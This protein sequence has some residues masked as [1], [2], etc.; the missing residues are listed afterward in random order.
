MKS[1]R[2]DQLLINSRLSKWHIYSAD[3]SFEASVHYALEELM[4]PAIGE[5]GSITDAP[6]STWFL[7]AP[8]LKGQ[9]MQK[10][11]SKLCNSGKLCVMHFP[12]FQRI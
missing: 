3:I 2:T 6:G 4:P 10:Q 9:I 12:P 5:V 7:K 8:S 11:S 1:N